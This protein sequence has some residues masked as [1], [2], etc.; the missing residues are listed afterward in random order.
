MLWFV[1]YNLGAF[2][3]VWLPYETRCK[4]GLTSAKD[5]AMK[6]RQKF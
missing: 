2:G 5:R 4:T 1:S 6:S 3:I